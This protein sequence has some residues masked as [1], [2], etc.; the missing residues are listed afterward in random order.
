MTAGRVFDWWF[1]N[2]ETGR[3]TIGQWPNVALTVFIVAWGLRRVLDPSGTA[4]TVLAVVATVAL[5]VWALDELIRG[6]NPWRR[7]L[8][9]VVLAWQVVGLL[10]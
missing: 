3:I 10:G 9:A 2:R 5:V 4:D 1:R 7:A 8:G 6:V